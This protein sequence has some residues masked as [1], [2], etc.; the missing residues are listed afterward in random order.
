VTVFVSS[1]D[2]A[3][4]VSSRVAG[5]RPRLGALDPS[6]LRDRETLEALGVSVYDLS[7]LNTDFTGHNTF[8]EVPAVVRQIGA[9]LAAAGESD[10][11]D[12]SHFEVSDAN[13]EQ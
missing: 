4:K 5:D 9:Q 7:R 10:D 8:A 11:T 6:N 13:N 3:L 12:R 1:T 2:R